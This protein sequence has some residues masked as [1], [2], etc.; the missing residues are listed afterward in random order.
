M[1]KIFIL[2]LVWTIFGA[3]V[4]TVAIGKYFIRLYRLEPDLEQF[5]ELSR[6]VINL[7]S[8]GI[9]PKDY[10]KD[11]LRKDMENQ[12]GV[13]YAVL[14]LRDFILWPSTLAKVVPLIDEAM[15]RIEDEYN[16]GIRVRKKPS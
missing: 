7:A 4:Y 10:K 15:Q 12:S 5:D 1:N 16:R 3:I 6:E 2:A 8:F 9:I 13:P 11:K 14:V